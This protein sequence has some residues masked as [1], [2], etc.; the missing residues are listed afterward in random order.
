MPEITLRNAITS[1]SLGCSRATRS[2]KRHS[3]CTACPIKV[4]G[5]LTGTGRPPTIPILGSL[6]GAPR[7]S[8]ADK[9]GDRKSTRLNSSH[10]EIYTLSLHDALPISHKGRGIIDRHGPPANHTDFGVF[11]GRAEMLNSR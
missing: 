4:E 3:R 5:S 11:E 10:T 8:I 2:C 7:C 9:I 1:P 6:K